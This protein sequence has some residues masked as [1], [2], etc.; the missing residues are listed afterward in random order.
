M[1]SS[2]V[3]AN[4]RLSHRAQPSST[5][6][7]AL[8]LRLR[9]WAGRTSV[10]MDFRLFGLWCTRYKSSDRAMSDVDRAGTAEWPLR[11]QQGDRPLASSVRD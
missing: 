7:T 10:A 5:A 4:I 8:M 2:K 11:L 9:A 1:W 6:E 3:N